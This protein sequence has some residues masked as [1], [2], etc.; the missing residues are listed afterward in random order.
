MLH[1]ASS[2][3]WLQIPADGI[4]QLP[5]ALAQG[6]SPTEAA[7][8]LREIGYALAPSFSAAFGAARDAAGAGH[9]TTDEFW[10]S[11]SDFF[12]DLGWGSLE[13]S[14]L[15]PGI[16]ALDAREWIDRGGHLSTGILAEI[17]SEA[18]GSEVAVMEITAADG[19]AAP[20]CRFLF[21]SPEALQALYQQLREGGSL[22]DAIAQL[23]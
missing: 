7:M 16:A 18:A 21:G 1:T 10:R 3:Q 11:L 6:R 13:F 12:S 15:H 9:L 8:L 14:Q 2:T 19:D 5:H 20:G 22:Q 4:G 23:A 17:L